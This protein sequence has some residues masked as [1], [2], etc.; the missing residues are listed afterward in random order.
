MSMPTLMGD[1][2]NFSKEPGFSKS[3]AG[4]MPEGSSMKR[5]HPG[6]DAASYPLPP[7]NE[8]KRDDVRL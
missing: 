3:P 5:R 6:R 4:R 7:Q 8:R 2:M 1:M